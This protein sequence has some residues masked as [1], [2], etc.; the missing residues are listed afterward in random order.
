MNIQISREGAIDLETPIFM[1]PSQFRNF[2]DSLNR[3]FD[4]A[5]VYN[6]KELDREM[7]DVERHA[8]NICIQH[9]YFHFRLL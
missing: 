6:V 2:R 8:K 3:I 7:S 9:D 5:K 1:S 4:V